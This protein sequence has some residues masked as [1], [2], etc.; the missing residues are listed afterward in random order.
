MLIWVFS[1]VARGRAGHLGWRFMPVP[2][3][4][5]LAALLHDLVDEA[6]LLGLLGGEPAVAVGVALDLLDGL[7]GVLGDELGHLASWC[8][9][10]ARP[11]S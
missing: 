3:D 11:G 7:A 1:S 4:V 10:S 6:V 8:R 2:P 9:A 5:D